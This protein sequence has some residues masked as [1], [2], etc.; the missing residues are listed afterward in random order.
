LKLLLLT[1]CALC[2]TTN[3]ALAA[4]PPEARH[5]P[6]PTETTPLP[7]TKITTPLEAPPE[8]ALPVEKPVDRILPLEVT[9]NGSKSGTWLLLERNGAMYAPRDAFE[10]W[11]VQLP[12]DTLPIDFKLYDQPYLPLSAIPGYKFKLDYAS[13]SAQLQFSPEVFSATRLIQEISKRPVVS[14]VLPSMF[15]NYD[16]NYST[17]YLRNN[18]DVKD[19]G[20]LAEIGASNSWG[21]L[22]SSHAGRNL[23]HDPSLTHSKTWVRMETTFTKDFPDQNRTLRLGD[24]V[25]HAGMWS[26]NVYFGGIQFGSNFALTPGFVS[27]PI[28][29]LPGV[30]TAPSTVEMYVNDVL[31]QVSNVPA[32]PFTIDNFPLLTGS[33]D[34]RMVVLDVLGRET[35]IE[36]SFFTS[37]QLLAKGLNDWSIEAG[38]IRKDIGV[39]SNHYGANFASGTWRHGYRNDLTFEG[40]TELSAQLKTLGTGLISTLPRQMLGK[41]SIAVSSGQNRNGALWLLGLEQQKLR[42][43]ASL[44][45]IGA[46]ANFH[47]LGQPEL[48]APTKLQLAGNWSY[49]T[50]NIG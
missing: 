16:L 48:T 35:V 50:E 49:T 37:T 43:S 15:V 44:Q 8:A 10:E 5:N 18:K 11:R 20:L 27:Q 34:V 17:S 13:Q 38:N 26:R 1:L 6:A 25:T 39:F 46:T 19:L 7:F 30:A 4:P 9:I 33:G 28:P 2:L 12:P 42:S 23:S 29:T 41:A 40:H 47:Q 31:R 3:S 24:T 45:L 36:Q 14:E 21:V 22:T 32:G